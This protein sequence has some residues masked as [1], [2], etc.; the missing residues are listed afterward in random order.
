[1]EEHK[2]NWKLLIPSVAIPLLVGGAAGILT[3]PMMKRFGEVEQPPLSPP[4]WLFPVAWTALYTAMGIA[5]YRVLKSGAFQR[6]KESAIKLYGLQ[7]FMNFLWPLLFFGFGF[8][9]F[10]FFWL[11][12][13]LAAVILT[14]VRFRR[15]DKAA[16]WLLVPYILWLCF[17]A[18]LNAGVALLN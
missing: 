6:E 10:S 16:G 7:L 17:A 2:I 15:I 8:Y 3:S 1:M 13:L 12:A 11:L 18:Y 9:G 14:A 5:S 4:G